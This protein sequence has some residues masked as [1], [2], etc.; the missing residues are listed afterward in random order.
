MMFVPD[1][2]AFSYVR[3][4]PGLFVVEKTIVSRHLLEC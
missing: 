4:C 2:F 3:D 1:F